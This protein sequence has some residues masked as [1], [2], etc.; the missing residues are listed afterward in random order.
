M[1]QFLYNL[2]I[3]PLTQVIEFVFSLSYKIMDSMGLALVGVSIAVSLLTLPL[4][5]VAKQFEDEERD[6]QIKMKTQT[7]RIKKSFKG[8]EQYMILSTYYRQNHYHP[9]MQLRSAL[10]ILIQIPFFTAAY[11][12]L[13]HM[14][15]LHGHSF[16][17]IADLGKPDALFRIG[18]FTV[19][20]LPLLMTA[21]NCVSGAIYT[22]GLPLREKLQVYLLALLFAVLLYNSPAGLVVYWT[23]NNVFSLVKNIFYKFKNPLKV[24][25]GICA[26]G[27]TAAI[28]WL[29]FT[30]QFNFMNKAR[31]IVVCLVI[32]VSPL[33][34]RA[35]NITVD[36]LLFPLRD[37]RKLRTGLF[38][39]G[40]GAFTLLIGLVIPSLLIASSPVEF[41]GI[42]SYPDPRFFVQNTFVQA[43]GLCFLWPSLVFFLF[44]E[45]IQTILSTLFLFFSLTAFADAFIFQGDYGYLSTLLVFTERS[46][47]MSPAMYTI[48]NLAVIVAIFAAVLAVI[49]L[50][51]LRGVCAVMGISC[52]ALVILSFVQGQNISAGYS[53]YLRVSAGTKAEAI[54]P[55][56]HFTQTGKNVVLIFLD[57]AQNRFVEPI[58]AETPRLKDSF[59]GFTLYKNT[60]SYNSHTLIG[61][62]PVH[63][64]YGY[65]PLEINRRSDVPLVEKH[66]EAILLLP[67]IFTEQAE[68]FSAESSDASW[69]NYSWIPDIS[70]FKPYPKI[71]AHV[72]ENAY[73]S[74]WYDE[75]RNDSVAFAVASAILKRNILWYAI[76]R[77]APVILRPV[78]Y[79]QGRYW[80]ANTGVEDANKYLSCYSVMEYLPRLT[81]FNCK[82]ENYFLSFTNN[83]THT[84]FMLQAPDYVPAA[85]ITNYSDSEYAHDS[86]YSSMAG[87]MHRLAEFFDYLKENGVYNNTRILIVSDHGSSSRDK[88]FKWDEK[89]ECLSPGRYHPLFMFKDFDDENAFATSDEFMTNADG[90]AMLLEGFISNPK[91]PFTGEVVTNAAKSNGALINTS[92][93]FMP[94]HTKSKYVLTSPSTDWYRVSKNIFE[95][96]NWKQELVEEAK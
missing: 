28:V 56:F 72:T 18:R 88:D 77:T 23:M 66:N 64:G 62:P 48:V 29:I 60:V 70:I 16:L 52:A 17:F 26:L 67:R 1:L 34:V 32:I 50:G 92:N 73:L 81:D 14:D 35:A 44:K 57:R 75:H 6:L 85:E 65:T 15:A 40:A 36:R 43:L 33:I 83:A 68:R 42:D 91:N 20:V 87:I 82:T 90:P 86:A 84:N 49:W 79:N 55:I 63:G 69:A 45:R 3:Y 37:N 58:L 80:S 96:E 74:L 2:V 31:M 41:S 5:A 27:C 11:A 95:S 4:Y 61:A 71:S 25:Y 19:N 12:C 46:N 38:F 13:S 8:D 94:H 39:A 21:I 89:F 24:F 9:I 53:E 51:L 76:F 10:G 78:I 22:K 30:H 93:L 59:S 47:V 7:N 54:S